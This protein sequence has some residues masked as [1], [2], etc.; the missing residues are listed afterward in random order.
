MIQ[1]DVVEEGTPYAAQ[2]FVP[3]CNDSKNTEQ[4][5][6]N[7]A[8]NHHQDHGGESLPCHFKRRYLSSVSFSLGDSCHYK[9][10][11]KSAIK[12]TNLCIFNK[13]FFFFHGYKLPQDGSLVA[14]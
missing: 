11:V 13:T 6:N 14:P 8:V 3:A 9:A 4:F 2:V 12:T 5:G 1:C 7:A 10:G